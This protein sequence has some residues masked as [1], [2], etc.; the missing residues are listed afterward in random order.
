MVKWRKN[1]DN[2]DEKL[3]NDNDNDDQMLEKISVDF[4]NG[5]SWSI[6]TPYLELH[7]CY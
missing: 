6:I 7:Y 4:T 1:N 5:H 3:K 2:D